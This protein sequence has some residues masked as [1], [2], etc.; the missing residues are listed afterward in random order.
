MNADQPGFGSSSRMPSGLYILSSGTFSTCGYILRPSGVPVAV[1][2]TAITLVGI[3][4]S[5]MM[6]AV[7]L[8]AICLSSYRSADFL[9][10]V[11]KPRF[12]TQHIEFRT[13]VQEQQAFV[14]LL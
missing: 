2:V 5:L 1:I 13:Q 14:V 9:E 10:D 7:Y 8:A 4:A 12:T 11:H 6:L 3:P